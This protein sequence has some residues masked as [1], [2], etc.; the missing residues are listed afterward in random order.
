MLSEIPN[1]DYNKQLCHAIKTGLEYLESLFDRKPWPFSC[2]SY[3][4]TREE[5]T[6]NYESRHKGHDEVFTHYLALRV[7]GEHFSPAIKER[8]IELTLPRSLDAVRYW[9]SYDA[10]PAD[11]DTTSLAYS[12]LLKL[13]VVTES[14]VQDVAKKVFAN[15]TDQGTVDLFFDSP[16]YKDIYDASVM[17]NVLILAYILK[18]E[19]QVTKTEDYVFNWLTSGQWKNGT[20][21]YHAGMIFLYY[22]L[23]VIKT[24]R[25]FQTRFKSHVEK[26]VMDCTPKFPLDVAFKKLILVNLQLDL[27]D[28]KL[29]LDR[30][31]LD[32][33]REDGSWPADG[34]W[35]HW[36]KVYWGGEAVSTM[37]AVA[38]L[39]SS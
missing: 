36:D 7:L 23:E 2:V 6:D 31:L 18:Q 30:T 33:Q 39:I 3:S 14:D 19:D 27:P 28:V 25:K 21:F 37:F 15:K 12:A 24:N 4:K 9:V 38:A 34:A 16:K 22:L 35:G 11:T 26:A 29:E 20:L 10:I 32:M 17:A 5:F 1:T 13:N 8:L